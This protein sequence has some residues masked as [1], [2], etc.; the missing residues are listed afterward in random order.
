[1]VGQRY[2][3]REDDSI[4]GDTA[5]D[6]FSTQVRGNRIIQTSNTVGSIL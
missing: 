2:P 3:R 5:H 1:M 6:R 4:A